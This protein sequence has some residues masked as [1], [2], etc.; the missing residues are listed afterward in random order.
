V[1]HGPLLAQW[2]IALAERELG[3]LA[4]FSFRAV[5]PLFHFETVEVC[6]KRGTDGLDL[7]V[8]GPDGRLAM[9]AEAR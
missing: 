4:E 5:A 6:A 1:I 2:L 7:W 3:E 8:R 9:T